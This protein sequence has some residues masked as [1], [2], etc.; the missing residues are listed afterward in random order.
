M[1]T[2]HWTIKKGQPQEDAENVPN[3]MVT[4]MMLIYPVYLKKI[5]RR[6][7]PE[8][9]THICMHMCPHTCICV[10]RSRWM[11]SRV[12]DHLNLLGLLSTLMHI[13][14]K[15]SSLPASS[16]GSLFWRTVLRL[17]RAHFVHFYIGLKCLRVCFPQ[18][19]SYNTRVPVSIS[20][21]HS[22]DV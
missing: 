5:M 16:P 3:N 4:A 17:Q 15:L 1:W 9:Y 12:G 18:N 2:C 21:Q 10:F 6:R 14:F 11:A 20:E 8:K 22:C 13:N 19:I 7:P